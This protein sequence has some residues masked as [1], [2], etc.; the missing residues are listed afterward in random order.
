[1][2][3]RSTCCDTIGQVGEPSVSNIPLRYAP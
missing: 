3:A 1:M 2:R